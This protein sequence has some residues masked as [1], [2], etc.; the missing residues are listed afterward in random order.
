VLI[1][2]A[3]NDD[4]VRGVVPHLVEDGLLILQFA[5]DTIIFMY[6]DLERAKNIKLLLSVFE[7]L[8]GLRLISTRARCSAM[9]LQRSGNSNILKFSNAILAHY[10]YDT[11]EYLC[12][13]VKS[14]TMIGDMT[15]RGFR[16]GRVVGIVKYFLWVNL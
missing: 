3:K 7:Q 9:E 11:R 1:N 6:N 12:I 13:T 14:T 5:D 4:Q 10:L 2:Q 15:K 16:N 8:S